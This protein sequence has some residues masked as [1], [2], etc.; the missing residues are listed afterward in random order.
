MRSS[1]RQ[2][3]PIRYGGYLGIFVSSLVAQVLNLVSFVIFL[4]SGGVVGFMEGFGSSGL[5]S[6]CSNMVTVNEQGKPIGPVK[7][8]M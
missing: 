4:F 8:K 1:H 2:R 5:R 3:R 7:Q 6:L